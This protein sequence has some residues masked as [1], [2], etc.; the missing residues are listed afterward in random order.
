MNIVLATRNKKKA[1][2]LNRIVE[3]MPV[4]IY[5]LNDFPDCPEIVED[6]KTFE[7]NAIKKAVAVSRF[8]KMPALA[9][10]SGLEVYELNGAPGVISARYSGEDSDDK[11]NYEKLLYEMRS[12]TD[13]KRGA[14]F[15]CVIV[16]AFPDGRIEKFSGYCEGRIGREPRGSKGF[17]YDP[18]F[19]P[20]GYDRTFAEMSDNEKDNLS[21]RGMALEKLHKFLIE[22]NSYLSKMTFIKRLNTS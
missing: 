20:A 4:K 22:N 8:T 5:T 14:R 9:D 2:E 7:E 21:H 13:E 15:A 6:G 17:G 1:E 19:Y 18:V 16:L 10:D 11:K 12:I 3:R